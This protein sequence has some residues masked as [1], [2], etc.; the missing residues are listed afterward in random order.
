MRQTLRAF[1]TSDPTLFKHLLRPYGM[2]QGYSR[3]LGQMVMETFEQWA[4]GLTGAPPADEAQRKRSYQILDISGHAALVRLNL[5]YPTRL[6]V[7]YLALSKID[8]EWRIV[9]K[10]WSGQRKPAAQPAG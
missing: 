3:T 5:D 6:G 8:G 2:V 1:A 7:D 4:K 9:T 10:A